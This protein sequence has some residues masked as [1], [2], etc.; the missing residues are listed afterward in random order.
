VEHCNWCNLD[1]DTDDFCIWCKRPIQRRTV[2]SSAKTDLHFLNNASSDDDDSP[3]FPVFAVIGIGAFVGIIAFAILSFKPPKDAPKEPEH[4]VAENDPLP[5]PAPITHPTASV[6]YRSPAPPQVTSP[7][8]YPEASGAQSTRSANTAPTTVNQ[9]AFG[10]AQSDG[11]DTG[12]AQ[13]AQNQS[14]Y[15]QSIDLHFAQN[16]SGASHLLGDVI[17]V[18]DTLGN[19]SDGKLT[20]TVG[21]ANYPL[22]R[23]DGSI[24]NPDFLGNFS[25]IP[26]ASVSCHVYAKGLNPT[27]M[28][29]GVRKVT[30]RANVQGAPVS[31]ESKLAIR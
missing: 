14:L 26:K 31:L 4:W 28:P 18:N 13:Y 12:I 16:S 27:T 19:L 24:S 3:R 22:V 21:T 20:L 17:V 1:S 8:E 25:I 30:L 11:G 2:Y 23:Y 6:P 10:L 9:T 5:A 7:A 15:F 29:T